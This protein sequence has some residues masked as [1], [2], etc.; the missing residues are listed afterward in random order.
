MFSHIG[1]SSFQYGSRIISRQ[2]MAE[3]ISAITNAFQLAANEGCSFFSVASNVSEAAAGD[4][5][6]SVNPVWRTA[7]LHA[8]IQTPWDPIGPWSM[9]ES[10]AGR[11]TSKYVAAF[12]AVTTG[13]GAYINEADPNDPRW[14]ENYYGM[15]YERLLEVKDKYDPDGLFHALTAVGSDRYREQSDGRLCKVTDRVSWRWDL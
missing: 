1:T 11:M 2:A 13:G 10:S 6:N 12:E 7:L 3:N 9:M 14:K 8:V 5:Y 15:N 4:V